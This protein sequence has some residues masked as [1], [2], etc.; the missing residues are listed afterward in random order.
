MIMENLQQFLSNVDNNNDQG[1]PLI[2]GHW[3]SYLPLMDLPN[4]PQFFPD[5]PENQAFC[6]RFMRR[7]HDTDSQSQNFIH[8]HGGAQLMNRKHLEELA[9]VL[10]GPNKV[11][12]A[13]PCQMQSCC[14]VCS[15]K[16]KFA[17]SFF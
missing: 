10:D 6:K 15:S 14:D 12:G 13:P 8:A 17:F 9:K 5:L 1:K 16:N 4:K 3:R 11:A 2:H 7:A